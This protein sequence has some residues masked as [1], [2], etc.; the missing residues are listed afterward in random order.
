[1]S[2]GS[3]RD[4]AIAGPFHMIV[5]LAALAAWALGPQ[6]FGRPLMRLGLRPAELYWVTAATEWLVLAIV[7]LGVWHSGA[8][9]STIL[10][11]RWHS[12]REVLRDAAVA[13]VFW[14]TAL[15]LLWLLSLIWRFAPT[16][17]L[18]ALLPQD[19]TD[20]IL[21]VGLSI[22]AGVCEEAIFRGYLQRQ[23]IALTRSAPAGIAL[24]A[25]L[26]GAAHA[27]QGARMILPLGLY[28]AM[29]GVLAYWR[30]NVRPGMI[31]HAW[32]DTLFGIAV[33]LMRH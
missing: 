7:A 4:G 5:V 27:Y 9:I 14:I 32:H 2:E 25:A 10:G 24:S 17:N 31:A 8:P 3:R 1:M 33:N 28:G 30:R 15:L 11:N 22:T 18:Q 20:L 29:F 13:A 12:M 26:F 23:F 6:L 21:W 19:R 16:R